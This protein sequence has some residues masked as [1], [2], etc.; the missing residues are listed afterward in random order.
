MKLFARPLSLFNLLDCLGPNIPRRE[1]VRIE[2]GNDLRSWKLRSSPAA[3]QLIEQLGLR[4]YFAAW[5]ELCMEFPHAREFTGLPLVSTLESWPSRIPALSYQ[6]MALVSSFRTG[7][8]RRDW[9]GLALQLLHRGRRLVTEGFVHH[10][11]PTSQFA[12]FEPTSASRCN[13]PN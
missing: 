13:L 7:I 12:K 1:R 10:G 3:R 5:P 11:R 2:A 9:P 8:W 4:F 6:E